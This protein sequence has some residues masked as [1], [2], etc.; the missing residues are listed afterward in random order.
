MGGIWKNSEQLCVLPSAI[1]L[2]LN[3]GDSLI[4]D[5]H[6]ELVSIGTIN[7]YGTI[8]QIAPGF[9]E[10]VNTLNEYCGASII[11]D[12][13]VISGHGKLV[14]ACNPTS[15]PEFPFSFSL[16]IM[17]VVVSVVYLGIRQKMM[18]NFKRF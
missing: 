6:A 15:I 14:D 10:I 12:P 9:I 11:G 17:F 13:P 16:V 4:I 1:I 5:T 3:A 2:N 18:P 8:E 7:N